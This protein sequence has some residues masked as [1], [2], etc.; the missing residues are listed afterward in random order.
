MWKIVWVPLLFLVVFGLATVIKPKAYYVNAVSDTGELTIND[1][2]K[3]TLADVSI[4]PQGEEKHEAAIFL[5]QEI[6][7]GVEIWFEPETEGYRVWVGCR[8][9]LTQ[10]DCKKGILVNEVIVK[11]GVADIR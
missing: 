3:I 5:L 8:R 10:M 2:R 1:G 11:A 9:F 4:A 7:K 6:T